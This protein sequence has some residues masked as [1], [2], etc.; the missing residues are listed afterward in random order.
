ML[1][2]RIHKVA[3][4]SFLYIYTKIT[5][6]LIQTWAQMQMRQAEA[7]SN[8]C[9]LKQVEA[10]WG[11]YCSNRS[12]SLVQIWKMKMTFKLSANCLWWTDTEH[13]FSFR[14]YSAHNPRQSAATSILACSCSLRLPSHLHLWSIPILKMFSGRTS[15]CKRFITATIITSLL[16]LKN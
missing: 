11:N 1:N 3:L 9:K 2:V 8:I 10:R 14:R 7:A 5:E 15:F 12:K 6:I 13:E 4:P 16:L